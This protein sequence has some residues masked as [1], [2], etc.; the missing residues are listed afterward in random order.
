MNSVAL[1]IVAEPVEPQNF[2]EAGAE[3]L[4]KAPA[5]CTGS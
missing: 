4:V 5:P 3:I 2:A 1:T